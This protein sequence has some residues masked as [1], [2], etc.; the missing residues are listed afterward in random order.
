MVLFMGRHDM[1]ALNL[2]DGE[3]VRADCAAD[4]GVERQVAG[5]KV[6]EYPLPQGCVA[7]YF[8]ECNPLIP[9]WHHARESKVPAAK[10]IP[11]RLS[12]MP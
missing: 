4:D 3:L 11:V 1:D 9:L 7:G 8:P 6:V 10:S 12:R 2:R 5:L